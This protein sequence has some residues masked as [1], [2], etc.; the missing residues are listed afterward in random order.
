MTAARQS[1]PVT[2]ESVPVFFSADDEGP[3]SR[4]G[5]VPEMTG[6]VSRWEALPDHTKVNLK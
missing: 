2:P 1:R 6:A 4:V 5:A 3:T